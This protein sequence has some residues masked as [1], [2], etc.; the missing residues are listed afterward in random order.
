MTRRNKRTPPNAAACMVAA[1]LLAAAGAVAAQ[2]YVAID[3]GWAW[4]EDVDFDLPTA[5]NRIHPTDFDTGYV[6]ALR[7]G[8]R[9]RAVGPGTP[10]LE[11]DLSYRQNDV[12]QF[13]GQGDVGPG[14]GKLKA[15]GLMVN[16]LYDFRFGS[17]F[18][19]YVGLGLGSVRVEADDI[20]K[21]ITSP[22]CCTGIIDGKDSGLAWQGI[23]GVAYEATQHWGV[24]LD[25]RYL[26][27]TDDLKYGYRAGCL[28]DGSACSRLPGDTEAKYRS[29][30]VSVGLRYAF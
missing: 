13:G 2:P 20:R 9:F 8:W 27:T 15:R 23:L 3:G 24:T 18:V 29:H 16:A 12:D 10:R 21:D 26:A 11:L 7:G 6:V 5:P 1:I 19:P 30:T 28:P 14:T 4:T 17:R 22:A 25:Y